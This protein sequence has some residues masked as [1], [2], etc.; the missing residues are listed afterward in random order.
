MI[1]ELIM[2]HVFMSSIVLFGAVTIFL[3]WLMTMSLKG[4]VKASANMKTTRKK[5]LMNLKKAI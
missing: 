2:N 3:Q 1:T 5:L 4:Y